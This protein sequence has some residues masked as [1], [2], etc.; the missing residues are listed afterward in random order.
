M[1][2]GE[3]GHPRPKSAAGGQLQAGTGGSLAGRRRPRRSWGGL[4]KPPSRGLEN[5]FWGFGFEFPFVLRR[6]SARWP[7]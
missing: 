3:S 2:W 1:L 5:G 6:A 4:R 7:D